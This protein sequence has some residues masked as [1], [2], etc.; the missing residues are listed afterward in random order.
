MA[1]KFLFL[2]LFLT[3]SLMLVFAKTGYIS[4]EKANVLDKPNLFAKQIGSL[5]Y[6][7]K[8]DY[9]EKVGAYYKIKYLEGKAYIH[10]SAISKDEI[11]LAKSSDK[12][13][14]IEEVSAATKGF[15]QTIEQDYKKKKPELKYDLLDIGEKAAFVK[16]FINSGKE[17]RKNGKL[18][19][20]S[21]DGGGK[22]NIL[23]IRV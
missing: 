16:D 18:C 13:A 12:Q 10:Q 11:A 14:S 19:E 2:F 20:F 4:V 15:N 8:V 1:Q 21:D 3:F 22:W 5:S 7:E 9:T 6:S 17:F 23:N